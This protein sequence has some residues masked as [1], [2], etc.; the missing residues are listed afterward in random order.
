MSQR[1]NT[2]FVEIR[3]IVAFI[4]AVSTPAFLRI[5]RDGCGDASSLIRF[6]VFLSTACSSEPM[7]NVLLSLG[8]G[9]LRVMAG[10]V[11]TAF[12]L[13]CAK[14]SRSAAAAAAFLSA[15]RSSRS[16]ANTF[17]TAADAVSRANSL[18]GSAKP[19]HALMEPAA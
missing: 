5:L 9:F 2:R 4:A 15:S 6:A 13:R 1:L 18:A 19:S 12:L 3:M 11:V 16:A 7:S 14:R 17:C 10:G 8:I